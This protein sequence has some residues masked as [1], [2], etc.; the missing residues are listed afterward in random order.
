MIV[1]YYSRVSKSIFNTER[2]F[3]AQVFISKCQTCISKKG[4][5]GQE[6]PFPFCW[7]VECDPLLL[8]A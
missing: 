7:Q 8:Q 3:S 2:H 4:S 6:S 5:G 1:Y